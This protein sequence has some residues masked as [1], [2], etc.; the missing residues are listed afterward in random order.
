M[1]NDKTKEKGQEVSQ[2]RGD[3]V[4]G[5]LNKAF[6]H[7]HNAQK[8]LDDAGPGYMDL[9]EK[10]LNLMGEITVSINRIKKW[11]EEDDEE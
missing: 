8:N 3:K 9:R 10:A 5:L 11:Q 4:I 1:D 2:R 6:N 7:I